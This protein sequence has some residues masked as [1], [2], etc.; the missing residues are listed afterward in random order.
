[1]VATRPCGQ[2]PPVAYFFPDAAAG[3]RFR[4]VESSNWSPGLLSRREEG[5]WGPGLPGLREE[6]VGGPDFLMWKTRV[7]RTR[8][9]GVGIPQGARQA[10]MCR[11]VLGT[12]TPGSEGE[13]G[14]TMASGV[15]G[16]EVWSPPAGL[17][18]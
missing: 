5:T 6:W 10:E 7:A 14:W 12:Q 4:G 16:I 9:R 11:W 15:E 8:T 2:V 13:E 18:A 1:M 17:R 3:V